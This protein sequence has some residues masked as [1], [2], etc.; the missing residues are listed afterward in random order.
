MRYGLVGTLL[1]LAAATVSAQSKVYRWV[2][3][4]GVVHFSDSRP[5]ESE[6]VEAETIVVPD[7][8]TR[9]E[10]I[11]PLADRATE[12]TLLEPDPAPTEAPNPLIPTF[13]QERECFAPSPVKQSGRDVYES[14][15]IPSLLT[16]EGIESLRRVVS[17]MSRRW[18]GK[19]D[20]FSCDGSPERKERRPSNREVTAE[21][22]LE[23]PDNFA[24]DYTL[25][26][27]SSNHR[28]RLRIALR[29]DQLW[30]NNGGATLFLASDRALAFGYIVQLGGALNEQYWR[31]ESDPGRSLAIQQMVYHHGAL[32]SSSR[33][34]LQ[35]R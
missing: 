16:G 5:N 20:G 17:E 8:P 21:G 34:D 4:N 3:A 2:D 9:F 30:V 28:E 6:N 7:L 31:I 35:P 12:S 19:E 1:L 25:S 23:S 24:F 29:N 33:W 26:T 11:R 27:G 13:D 10:T 15:G 18:S 22:R 32:I 14:A